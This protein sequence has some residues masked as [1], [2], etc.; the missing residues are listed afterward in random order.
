MLQTCE[1]DATATQIS[2]PF[3]A[4]VFHNR[5]ADLDPVTITTFPFRLGRSW[6]GLKVFEGAT[7]ILLWWQKG[8]EEITVRTTTRFSRITDSNKM[9]TSRKQL[10]ARRQEVIALSVLDPQPHQPLLLCIHDRAKSIGVGLVVPQFHPNLKKFRL[11]LGWKFVRGIKLGY[12][13]IHE[14]CSIILKYPSECR[15]FNRT[16]NIGKY[17]FHSSLLGP[18]PQGGHSPK[19]IRITCWGIIR[20]LSVM[21]LKDSLTSKYDFIE[22][23]TKFIVGATTRMP[24]M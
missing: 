14:L 12:Y 4:C 23:R 18:G 24:C 1:A 17:F 6:N 19:C 8:T 16:A 11:G 21:F 15:D 9:S 5:F 20:R 10:L 2:Q 7:P 13:C 22:T 3:S